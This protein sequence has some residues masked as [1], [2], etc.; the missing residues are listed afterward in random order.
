MKPSKAIFI[1]LESDLKDLTALETF[2]VMRVMDKYA[3]AMNNRYTKEEIIRAA[4]IG[5]VS[6]IDTEHLFDIL[7]GR[8]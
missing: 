1:E 4:E 7:E 6:P 5:E 8:K 3:E 2:A